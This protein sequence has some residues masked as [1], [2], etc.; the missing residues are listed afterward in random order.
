[1][2]RVRHKVLL[3]LFAAPSTLLPLVGGMTALIASWA[4]GGDPW[5]TFGGITSVLG[6][7][8]FFATRLVFGIES[9]TEKAH[10]YVLQEERQ[11]RESALADLDRRL[12]QDNDPRPET[13]LRQLRQLYNQFQA[14]IQQHGIRA[15]SLDVLEKVEEMFRVCVD[16]LEQTI[17][18]MTAAQSVQGAARQRI[19]HQR[20]E[21]I[22][23]VLL[24]VDHVASAVQRYEGLQVKKHSQELA[25]LREELDRS[26]QAA[27]AA[28]QRMAEW[29]KQQDSQDAPS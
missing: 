5:L 4:I 27:R 21:I 6:G 17:Q 18:L 24:T 14:N 23:E 2:S 29:E 12:T 19:L 8:G 26:L 11:Q 10:A 9:L 25:R 1:M 13:A 28:E 20:E 7:A 15:A 3:D 16:Q 22:H